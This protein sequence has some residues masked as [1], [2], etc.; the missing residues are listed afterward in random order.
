[1]LYRTRTHPAVIR[2][3]LYLYFSSSRSFRLAA[4][5]LAPIKKRSHIAIWKW[6]QKYADCAAD[7]FKTNNKRLVKKIFVDETMLQV[8]GQNYWLWIAYEPNLNVCLSMHLSRERRTIFFV[9]Y[10]FFKQLRNRF[11]GRKPIFTDGARWYNDACKW[12]RL[13]H[14]VYGTELK[15]IMERFIHQH[16]KDRTECFDDHFPCR[17]EGCEMQHVW[18]W[19]KLLFVLYFHAGM[20]RKRFTSFLLVRNGG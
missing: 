16:I 3:G 6:V 20:D 13:K 7:R 18:N 2:Y 8:D 4:K 10:Q 12:L 5:S 1:M 17:K 14:I 9:C 11:G 15:N 19:L